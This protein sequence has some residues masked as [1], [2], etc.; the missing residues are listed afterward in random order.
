MPPETARTSPPNPAA[1][2]EEH[3]LKRRIAERLADVFAGSRDEIGIA[4]TGRA[5]TLAGTL[6]SYAQKQAVI[7]AALSVDGVSVLADE[8]RVVNPWDAAGDAEIAEEAAA[9]LARLPLTPDDSVRATVRSGVVRLLGSVGGPATR[10]KAETA[11]RWGTRARGVDNL[12]RV[13]AGARRG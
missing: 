8:L 1:Q 2:A 3:V 5:V 13:E 10:R 12:L 4:V 6:A 7:E 9:A 11:I